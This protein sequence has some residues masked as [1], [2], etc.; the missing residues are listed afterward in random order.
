MREVASE[1]SFEQNAIAAAWAARGFISYGSGLRFHKL[2][3]FGSYNHVHIC[4]EEERRVRLEG[5]TVHRR[6]GITENDIVQLLPGVFVA[7]IPLGRL[8]LPSDIATA[9]VFLASD[10]AGLITGSTLSANGGQV[11]V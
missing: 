3:S 10:E 5:A 1:S 2:R 8:S 11:M 6:R 9:A 7:S 4:I